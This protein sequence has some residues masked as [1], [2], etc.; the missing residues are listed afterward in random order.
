MCKNIGR[1][2]RERLQKQFRVFDSFCLVGETEFM[3]YQSSGE[4]LQSEIAYQD[5]FDSMRTR[6]ESL[7]K[8]MCRKKRFVLKKNLETISARLLGGRSG[9]F[10]SSTSM[11]PC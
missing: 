7:R 10:S 1:I 9:L 5:V 6:L 11:L 8:N 4:F 3:E 2:C